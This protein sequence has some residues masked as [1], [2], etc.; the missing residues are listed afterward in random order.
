[1]NE[2]AGTV[3]VIFTLRDDLYWS[4]Y[5]NAQS[6]VPVTSDDVVFWY[7]GISGD[8]AFNSSAYPQQYL[9]KEDGSEGHVDIEKIS[10]KKFALHFPRI[11]ADPLL[12]CNMD[13]GPAHIYQKA[14]EEN[15]VQGVL[16]LYSVATDPKTI[17]SMGEW[18]LVEYIPG[19]RLMYKRNPDYWKKDAAGV[20][21]PYAE[22]YIARIIPDENTQRLIFLEGE[23][24]SYS[25]KPEDLAG[26]AGKP[27]V[28]Y[29]VFNAEGSL[30]ASYWIF[31]QN[32]L[33]QGSPKYT[34]FTQKEFRQAMSSLLNRDRIISQVYRGLGAP[35]YDFFPEPNAFYNG[36]ITLK[37]RYNVSQAL[38]LL[39]SIGIKKDAQGVMRDRDNNAVE[40]DL[41]IRSDSTI[42]TDIAS[43]IMDELRNVGIKVNIRTLDFQ[44][45]VEQLMGTYEWDSMIMGLSG[46]NIFPS[47]GSNVWP[48]SGNLHMWNPN[49]KTP[50]TTWEARIDYLYNEGNYT[51]DKE[52]AK[53]I[54]DEYQEILLE[55]CPVI[56]LIRSRGFWALRNRWDFSNVYYDNVNGAETAHIFLK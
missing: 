7:N 1:V 19:Q 41:T 39:E 24:E 23:T 47:Q 52:K 8:P 37:Y 4:Y 44:K 34:W 48:S 51:I 10:N 40:F 38:A 27:D 26:M 16:D 17:P 49:Q 29:T 42:N 55:Q 13:F 5:N 6:R 43:I 22:E 14:K 11:I 30:G 50:A 2:A 15:G 25:L 12:A 21:I 36:D 56:S 33:H 20:S 46:S 53:I 35:K 54:W 18:F 31:N 28:D 32:P 9:V 45:Q 3:S